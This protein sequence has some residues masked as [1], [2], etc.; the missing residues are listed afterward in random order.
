M[1]LKKMSNTESLKVFREIMGYET[2]ERRQWTLQS[3]ENR[4]FYFGGQYTQEEMNDIADR[5]Q[6]PH[7]INKI[8]KAIRG[9]TGMFASALPKFLFT[10]LGKSDEVKSSI[11]NKILDWVFQNSDGIQGFKKIVKR[12]AIDN[13][14][15]FHVIYSNG[16]VKYLPLT[17]EDVLVPPHSKDSLFRD[18]GV[19]GI[20]KYIPVSK[21]Q[22]L[23]G[24]ASFTFET[25]QSYS[26]MATD[27]SMSTFLGKI[28][29][30]DEQHVKIYELYRKIWTRN[31]D[32]SI[33]VRIQKE[34]VVGY[35]HILIEQLPPE[36]TEIPII[37]LYVEDTE[38][39][40]KLGEVHFLKGLQKFINKAFGVTLYNAQ[41]LSNPKVLVRETD[42]PNMDIAAFED[43]FATP[44]AIGLLTGNAEAPIIVQGQPLNNA[45]F[46][47]YQ[48]AKMEFEMATM[49]SE[50]LGYNNSN[51]Q[52][53]SSYLLDKKESVM[54]SFKDFSANIDNA[55]RHLAV[56][57]IQYVRG[58]IKDESIL[59]IT[60]S[61]KKYET[62][63]L[64]KRQG[65]DMKNEQSVQ[66]FV[67]AMKQRGA[68]DGEIADTL[69]KAAED[70]D[71]MD[72]LMEVINDT[73]VMNYDIT[74]IPGSYSPTYE[75]AMLRL[76]FELYNVGAV[77]NTSVLE[78][79]P[80]SNKKEIIRRMDTAMR[81]QAEVDSL[82]EELEKMG[83]NSNARQQELTN[84]KIQTVV[85]QAAMKE[86]K[87]L[88]DTKLKAYLSKQKN[89]LLTSKM[90]AEIED[91]ARAIIQD[92]KIEA[93]LIKQQKA[94]NNTTTELNEEDQVFFDL[95]NK[96]EY[97]E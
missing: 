3:Q 69:E 62:I 32:G 39:P 65:L 59:R 73:S 2:P 92:A 86:E 90:I 36:I 45:F 80:I 43:N 20:Y 57:A 21:A 91:K 30:S 28:F 53:N 27:S 51:S 48:D 18:A 25:P 7:V 82:K 54:D 44:G 68:S 11:S 81:L 47:M 76:M 60:D 19:I 75:M 95:V 38:N 96:G 29:S 33:N 63:E 4:N 12:A 31:E 94:I 13:I 61:E 97:D 26:D 46:A 49:P 16:I 67:Q 37:P 9:I 71:Y 72:S 55:V 56:I 89:R 22:A 77:D 64:N 41:M 15:Y 23:Y 35:E 83:Q 17:F 42:I 50:V 5:G 85:D 87:I 52:Q 93:Q 70:S 79:A 66:Q 84:L 34:T 10:P 78:K 58:Y 1:Q 24:I 40:Y 6:Y 14:G 88:N 8:R 74:V